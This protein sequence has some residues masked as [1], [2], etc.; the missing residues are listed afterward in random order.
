MPAKAAKGTRKRV[1][2]AVGGKTDMARPVA[3]EGLNGQRRLHPGMTT[4][5]A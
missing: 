2:A 3:L 4:K 5:S 1:K